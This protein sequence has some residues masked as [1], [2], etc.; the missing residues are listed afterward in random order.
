MRVAADP[1]AQRWLALWRD[2]RTFR[3]LPRAGGLDDQP[4]PV[5]EAFTVCDR[6]LAEYQAWAATEGVAHA[7]RR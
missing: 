2:C 6:A 7:Q 3:T 1:E 5:V 4:A